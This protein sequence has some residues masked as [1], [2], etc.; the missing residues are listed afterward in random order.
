MIDTNNREVVKTL[1][2][3]NEGSVNPNLQVQVLDEPGVGGASHHYAVVLKRDKEPDETV[4]EV[5]FQ[6][7]AIQEAGINGSTNEAVLAIVID[8][9]EGFQKGQYA[10]DDTEMALQHC[11]A[12]LNAL[13]RRTKERAA[14]G[15]EGKHEK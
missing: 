7:G 10:S 6:K 15:V 3:G 4:T 9:L 12:A 8:R 2:A 11:R 5:R 13:E 1:S 14:R